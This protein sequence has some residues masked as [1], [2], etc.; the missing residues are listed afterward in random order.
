[1]V[2]DWLD[3]DAWRATAYGV[4]GLV[5]LLAGLR[6]R[7]LSRQHPH[8][9]L[10]PMFWFLTAGLLIAM[11]LGQ[12]FDLDGLLT[13]F[14]RSRSRIEGWY[15]TRRGLQASLVAV[16]T[17]GW[18]IAVSVA[19]W[20]VP[21]RRRRYLPMAVVGFTMVGFAAIRLISLHHVDTLLYRRDFAGVRIVAVL[22]WGLIVLAVVATLR[23]PV[24]P[25]S[26]PAAR[27]REIAGGTP[28]AVDI[29]TVACPH[30]D[31]NVD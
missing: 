28:D 22:E 7:A 11:A 9:A 3:S 14:G 2:A 30:R 26:S 5:G 1:M 15:R 23:Q 16:V 8:V 25:T 4:V 17:V 27:R 24:E 21:E 18:M 12:A 13:E 10:W 19:I 31:A 6:E 29:V 20:R